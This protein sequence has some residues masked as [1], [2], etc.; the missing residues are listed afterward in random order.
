MKKYNFIQSCK[1]KTVTVKQLAD[2]QTPV[3]I[4]LKIRDMYPESVLLES[5]DFH[6]GENAYTFIGF[7]PIARFSAEKGCI[8]LQYPNQPKMEIQLNKE[9]SLVEIFNEFVQSFH[10]KA[11]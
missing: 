5:S 7:N 1:I 10:A 9:D 4:Y 2:L 11:G 6:G 8:T 3:E